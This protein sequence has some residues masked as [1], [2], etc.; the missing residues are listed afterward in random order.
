MLAIV[1]RGFS[2]LGRRSVNNESEFF[3][4]CLRLPLDGR[5]KKFVIDLQGMHEELDEGTPPSHNGSSAVIVPLFGALARAQLYPSPELR[6]HLADEVATGGRQEEWTT[7]ELVELL[8]HLAALRCGVDALGVAFFR[9]WAVMM[10]ERLVGECEWSMLIGVLQSLGR[11]GIGPTL[12]ASFFVT[13]SRLCTAHFAV[14]SVDQLLEL[15]MDMEAIP[16]L[17]HRVHLDDGFF[18]AWARCLPQLVTS[19]HVMVFL[20]VVAK[21]ELAV[22]VEM[23]ESWCRA[24]LRV[25]ATFSKSEFIRV[26]SDLRRLS[27]TPL[28]SEFCRD[29]FKVAPLNVAEVRQLSYALIGRQACASLSLHDVTIS[30]LFVIGAGDRS[31]LGPL[32]L[33]DFIWALTSLELSQQARA[34]RSLRTWC[35][36]C[37]DMLRF[38]E[39]RDLARLMQGVARGGPRLWNV[40][41]RSFAEEW[42]RACVVKM[43]LRHAASS[44]HLVPLLQSVAKLGPLESRAALSGSDDFLG[45]WLECCRTALVDMGPA[46]LSGAL[47]TLATLRVESVASASAFFQEWGRVSLECM[48]AF[49][50]PECVATLEAVSSLG[51][52]LSLNGRWFEAWAHQCMLHPLSTPLKLRALVTTASMAPFLQTH[53]GAHFFSHLCTSMRSPVCKGEFSAAELGDILYSVARSKREDDDKESSHLLLFV[54]AAAALAAQRVP[55][56]MLQKVLLSCKAMDVDFDVLVAKSIKYI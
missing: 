15:A 24:C 36:L 16:E 7:A 45:C 50:G 3:H 23:I 34:L 13:W 53:M 21:R 42:S 51:L 52:S 32:N 56:A 10:Q 29:F 47:S 55:D 6:R 25:C 12:L 54:D 30:Q 2:A 48:S 1:V 18:V 28:P 44:L 5:Q 33:V 26:L 14:L 39:I 17:D 9:D 20:H 35:A 27:H 8:Q 11:L 38:L 43:R 41:G 22:S 46:Q 49:H 40:V 4:R 19:H 37:E 31:A